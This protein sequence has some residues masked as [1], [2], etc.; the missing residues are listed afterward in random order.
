MTLHLPWSLTDGGASKDDKISSTHPNSIP[1]DVL[2]SMSQRKHMKK[3]SFQDFRFDRLW[4]FNVQIGCRPKSTNHI[5]LV[6]AH[7]ISKLKIDPK[8]SWSIEFMVKNQLLYFECYTS[9]IPYDSSPLPRA[10]I[11]LMTSEKFSKHGFSFVTS[12]FHFLLNFNWGD[13]LVV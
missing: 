3:N 2:C 7:P 6:F 5:I 1:S 8:K 13:I 9:I 10:K 4:P 11:R 12:F